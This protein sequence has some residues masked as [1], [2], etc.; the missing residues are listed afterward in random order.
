MCGAITRSGE[1]GRGLLWKESGEKHVR[2][3]DWNDYEIAAEGSRIRTWI[4]GKLCVDLDDLEGARRGIFALQI[5]SGGPMEVRFK[6]LRLEVKSPKALGG[7]LRQ[8]AP[9]R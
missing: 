8:P 4:N 3:G 7:G 2:L 9:V 1:H 6:D 5:H